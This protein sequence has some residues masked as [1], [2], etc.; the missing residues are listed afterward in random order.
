MKRKEKKNEKK[1]RK[2]GEKEKKERK[3]KKE[4]K[5]RKKERKEVEQDGGYS[6]GCMTRTAVGT[7]WDSGVSP[8]MEKSDTFVS[9]DLKL[10]VHFMSIKSI[11]SVKSFIFCNLG[12]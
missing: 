7:E 12:F 1:E 3:E 5:E 8:S 11:T 2:G 10:W 9:R 4:K 6:L